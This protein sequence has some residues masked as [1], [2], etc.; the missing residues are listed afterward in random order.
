M[1]IK[2]ILN[3]YLWSSDS[4]G[5]E[6]GLLLVLGIAAADS[7][8]NR[9]IYFFLRQINFTIKRAPKPMVSGLHKPLYRNYTNHHETRQ[10]HG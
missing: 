9:A 6:R 2:N 5:K 7:F 3:W 10:T 4:L 1:K 8:A